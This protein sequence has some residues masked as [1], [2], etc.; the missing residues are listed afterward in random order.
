MKFSYRVFAK[1]FGE[2]LLEFLLYVP[3][4]VESWL[5]LSEQELRVNKWNIGLVHA[6]AICGSQLK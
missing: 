4:E 1:F 3:N 6:A 2:Q 5:G